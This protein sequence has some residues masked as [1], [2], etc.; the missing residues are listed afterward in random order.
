[1]RS[2]PEVESATPPPHAISRSAR[3]VIWGRRDRSVRP[4]GARVV[5]G[6]ESVQAGHQG[7]ADGGE[8]ARC[9]EQRG[10]E[11]LAHVGPSTSGSPRSRVLSHPVGHAPRSASAPLAARRGVRP[12]SSNP[13]ASRFRNAG[14]SSTTS[15]TGPVMPRALPDA[16]V[17]GV[18]GRVR[19]SRGAVSHLGR[20][21]P[22]AVAVAVDA[23]FRVGHAPPSGLA[24]DT[25]VNAPAA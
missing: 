21:G 20:H 1:M 10:A 14:S 24:R 7:V 5:V 6:V 2:L 13:C 16:E 17:R 15:A 25:H 19:H 11:R 8:D 9:G 4:H 3:V 23:V 22:P 18:G 12:A